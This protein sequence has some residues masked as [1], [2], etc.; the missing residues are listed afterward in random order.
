MC[1]AAPP[2]DQPAKLYVAP[3]TVCVEGALTWTWEFMTHVCVNGAAC[4]S[5]SPTVRLNPG[6][7]VCSVKVATVGSI[8][9]L[10]V[11]DS[12]ALS[13]AVSSN[14][15]CDGAPCDGAAIVPLLTPVRVAS[16][17]S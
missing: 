10:T 5:W 9:R 17:C 2:S 13:V 1:V 8:D 4:A 3:A 6:G 7:F 16:G 12:P 11:V 14:T 15:R